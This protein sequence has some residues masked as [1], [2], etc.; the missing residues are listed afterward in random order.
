VSR[1]ALN[2]YQ[3]HT[4]IQQVRDKRSPEIV[5]TERRHTRLFSPLLQDE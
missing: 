1:E 3:V 4:R 5:R 2:R